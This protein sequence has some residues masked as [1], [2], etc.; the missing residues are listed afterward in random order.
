MK[1]DTKSKN[2]PRLL[3]RKSNVVKGLMVSFMFLLMI[4]AAGN[5]LAQVQII[6]SDG[7]IKEIQNEDDLLPTNVSDSLAL[8]AIYHSYAFEQLHP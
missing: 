3:F 1:D 5:V 7:E 2:G 4:F 8:V 6:T